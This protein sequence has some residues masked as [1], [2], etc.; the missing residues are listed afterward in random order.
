MA[1]KK[2]KAPILALLNTKRAQGLLYDYIEYTGTIVPSLIS[3][4]GRISRLCNHLLSANHSSVFWKQD[5]AIWAGKDIVERRLSPSATSLQHK[6]RHRL[7]MELDQNNRQQA[8]IFSHLHTTVHVII[9]QTRTPS[10]LSGFPST[11]TQHIVLATG[12]TYLQ[13]ET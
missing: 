2:K 13:S 3:K 6:Y 5:M 9:I 8:V 4:N 1:E 10:L 11:P 7:Q 12:K